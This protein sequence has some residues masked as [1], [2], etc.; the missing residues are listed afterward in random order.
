MGM[1]VYGVN[2]KTITEQPTKPET[3]NYDSDEWSAYWEARREW[4]QENP[5]TYFRN[6][7]WWWR[8]LW[9]YVNE[10]CNDVLTEE[11]L[12]NGHSNSGHLI[13]EAKC[14]IISERLAHELT[15]GKVTEYKEERQELL[16]NL[17]N[18]PC[19][20]CEGSGKGAHYSAGKDTCHTC[21]GTGEREHFDKGY[22][23]NEDNVRKFETFVRTSGGFRIS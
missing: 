18:Q 20:T 15:L 22:P 8:P 16:D 2:P 14:K 12:D 19:S 1:D 4:E 9:A 3:E 10:I 11:D 13:D 5:G 6:N 17:P 7:V 23:F 21:E